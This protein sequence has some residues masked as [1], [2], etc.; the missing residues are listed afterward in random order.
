MGPNLAPRWVHRDRTPLNYPENRVTR[1]CRA[2]HPACSRARRS[3]RTGTTRETRSPNRKGH[4]EFGDPPR[5]LEA[6]TVG[7]A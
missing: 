6:I 1:R 4:S 7:V 5:I 3:R 2:N